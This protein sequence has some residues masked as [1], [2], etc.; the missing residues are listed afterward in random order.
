MVHARPTAA[1]TLHVYASDLPRALAWYHDRFGLETQPAA[2]PAP[3]A[4][5]VG[6]LVS[7]GDISLCVHDRAASGA[8]RQRAAGWA[9]VGGRICL[10][11][12]STDFGMSLPFSCERT[13]L[14]SKRSSWEGPPA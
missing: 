12:P 4:T 13:G 8:T 9:R 6:V 10:E 11:V 1:G 7:N 14:W 2:A 5:P 3:E